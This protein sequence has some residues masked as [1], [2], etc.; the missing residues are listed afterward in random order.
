MLLSKKSTKACMY[1]QLAA[2]CGGLWCGVVVL[3][4][5]RMIVYVHMYV[6]WKMT[7][8]PFLDADSTQCKILSIF[9]TFTSKLTPRCNWCLPTQ[10]VLDLYMYIQIYTYVMVLVLV[11]LYC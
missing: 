7:A 3:C 1:L 11:F 2:S 4:V 5:N 10:L 8:Q 6:L 9:L